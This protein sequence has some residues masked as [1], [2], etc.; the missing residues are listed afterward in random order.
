M[1]LMKPDKRFWDKCYAEGNTG[2]DRGAVHPALVEWIDEGSLAPCRVLVPGCGRG[3]EVEQLARAGFEVM[4]VDYAQEPLENLRQRIASLSNQPTM[5]Q[6]DIFEYVPESPFDA[7][8]EQTCL[9]AIA[10]EQRRDYERRVHGWLKPGGMLFALFMQCDQLQR[11][12]G[13]PGGPPFHCAVD[14]MRKLFPSDRWEWLDEPNQKFDHPNGVIF[15]AAV[16]LKRRC[17]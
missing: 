15:E 1:R 8:Y 13:S 14:D 7:I 16:R 6:Q 12:E 2:W 10:P 17:D 4:A 5:I 3:Y 9:C 11:S